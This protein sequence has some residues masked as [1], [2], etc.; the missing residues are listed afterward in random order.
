MSFHLVEVHQPIESFDDTEPMDTTVI[1]VFTTPELA[2]AAILRYKREILREDGEATDITPAKA[3]EAR[4][5]D[6][7]DYYRE[8]VF[9]TTEIALDAH[10]VYPS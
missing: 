3:V 4:W 7:E 9:S 10:L 8:S 1:G 2:D 6:P 5:E